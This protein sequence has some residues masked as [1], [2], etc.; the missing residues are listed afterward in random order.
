MAQLAS[1]QKGT[2]HSGLA[3][4]LGSDSAVKTLGNGE[5]PSSSVQPGSLTFGSCPAFSF[6]DT[7]VIEML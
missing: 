6:A 4:G 3:P 7:Q 2:R 5:L 1:P